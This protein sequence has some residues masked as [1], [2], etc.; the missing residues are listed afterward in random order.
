MTDE[1]DAARSKEIVECNTLED[2]LLVMEGAREQY[3]QGFITMRHYVQYVLA[4][5]HEHYKCPLE[6][7][8]S[9]PVMSH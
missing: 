4:K 3:L 1:E 7:G 8:E 6:K 5:I 9:R 2:L